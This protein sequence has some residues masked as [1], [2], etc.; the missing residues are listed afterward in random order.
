MA[1]P[2]RKQIRDAAAALLSGVTT[3]KT[4][5]Y[6][7]RRK[8]IHGETQLPA[9]FVTLGDEE[10]EAITTGLPRALLHEAELVI[11]CKDHGSDGLDDRLEVMAAA[12]TAALYDVNLGGL[13]KEITFDRLDRDFPSE[14]EKIIGVFTLTFV[15]KYLTAENDMTA[16]L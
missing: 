15:V 8:P 5:V 10:A 1:D 9:L 12:V 2:V 4:R 13:I 7:T 3:A 6:A 11:E 14:G 16:A